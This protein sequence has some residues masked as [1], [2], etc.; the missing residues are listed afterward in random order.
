MKLRR[1]K[2]QVLFW[3]RGEYFFGLAWN[4]DEWSIELHLVK[5]ILMLKFQP[6]RED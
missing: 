2:I 4:Q 5:L 3:S 1:P 6:A